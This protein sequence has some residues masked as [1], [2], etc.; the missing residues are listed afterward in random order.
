MGFDEY[1]EL[2]KVLPYLTIVVFPNDHS[3][4][5]KI[6]WHKKTYVMKT[7]E[8]KKNANYETGIGIGSNDFIYDQ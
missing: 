2:Y 4:A 3:I 6:F 7:G 8:K 5:N 1:I